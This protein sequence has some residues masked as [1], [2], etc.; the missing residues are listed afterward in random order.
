MLLLLATFIV[1]LV[2]LGWISG[3]A[4]S[5]SVPKESI[6]V[7]KGVAEGLAGTVIP[8]YVLTYGNFLNPSVRA[9]VA[10]HGFSAPLVLLDKSDTFYPSDMAIHISNT[11]GALNFTPIDGAPDRLSLQNLHLLNDLGGDEVYLTSNDELIKMPK[12]LHG[13]KPDS[14]TLQTT[15][16]ISCVIIVV[17]KGEGI[18]DAFYMYFYTFNQGPSVMSHELGD[19]LG[20]WYVFPVS[21]KKGIS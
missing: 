6:A 19:H 18:V 16:A 12:Y 8:G 10:N 9:H 14:R 17:D 1:L 11:H 3:L 21:S 5:V 15:N 13:K 7:A 20:D 4:E 2:V